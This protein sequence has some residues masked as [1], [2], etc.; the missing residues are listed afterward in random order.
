MEAQEGVGSAAEL[1]G[2]TTGDVIYLGSVLRG[3][4]FIR[5]LLTQQSA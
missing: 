2:V 5:T 4:S 1:Q 3:V